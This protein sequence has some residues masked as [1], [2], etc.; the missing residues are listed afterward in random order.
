MKAGIKNNPKDKDLRKYLVF[1]YLKTGEDDLAVTQL[2]EILKL[3]PDDI[4]ILMQLARLQEKLG[5]LED[6]LA[7]YRKIMDI[8]P[9]HEEAGDAYLRLR[10]EV[11]PN[12]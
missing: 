12:E 6:A 3:S 4:S 1:A 2:N 9:D 8:S 10:L 11:L 5:K 7:T